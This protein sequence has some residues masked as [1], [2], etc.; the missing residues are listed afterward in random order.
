MQ[1]QHARKLL[2]M[3]RENERK[4]KN[5]TEKFEAL[6]KQKE[7]MIA[8]WDEKITHTKISMSEQIEQIKIEH[9]V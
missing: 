7:Q 1:D 9:E 8:D 6:L 5:D 4:L 2:A 3:N